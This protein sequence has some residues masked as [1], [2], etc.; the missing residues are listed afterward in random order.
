MFILFY[1]KALG[2][3]YAKLPSDACYSCNAHVT[4][5]NRGR[6]AVRPDLVLLGIQCNEFGIHCNKVTFLGHLVGSQWLECEIVLLVLAYLLTEY[7]LRILVFGYS[8]CQ[9]YRFT[10]LMETY[11]NKWVRVQR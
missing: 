7:V 11:V 10:F 5:F 1:K 3:R 4:R 2:V 9:F 8:F 6:F